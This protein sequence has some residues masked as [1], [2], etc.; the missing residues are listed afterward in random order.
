MYEFK[1]WTKNPSAKGHMQEE[2][3]CP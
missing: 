1:L 3:K 2:E